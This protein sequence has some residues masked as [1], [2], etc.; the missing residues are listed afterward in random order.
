MLSCWRRRS[1][2]QVWGKLKS[3]WRWLNGSNTGYFPPKTRDVF[4][5]RTVSKWKSAGGGIHE[6]AS[7]FLYKQPSGPKY[8]S[9][10]TKIFVYFDLNVKPMFFCDAHTNI[11][12]SSVF[13]LTCSFHQKHVCMWWPLNV[14]S[15]CTSPDTNRFTKCIFFNGE[16]SVANQMSPHRESLWILPL[17]HLAFPYNLMASDIYCNVSN[18]IKRQIF[19]GFFVQNEFHSPGGQ[20]AATQRLVTWQHGHWRV[21]DCCIVA[22]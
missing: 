19:G 12:W 10:R 8:F 11:S 7:G 2:L 14:K 3:L 16:S 4:W 22:Y 21:S 20:K 5:I 6:C 18:L 1:S 9:M 15:A 13:K 17:K